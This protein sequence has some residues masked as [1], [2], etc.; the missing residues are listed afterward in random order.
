MFRFDPYSAA[1]DADRFP[2][3]RRLREEFPCFWSEEANAWVLSRFCDIVTALNDWRTYS[4]AKGELMTEPPDC[5]GATLGAADPPRPSRF[6]IG[7]A[8]A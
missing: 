1:V 7:A 5:A 8:N 3:Y 6:D 2:A 4:S